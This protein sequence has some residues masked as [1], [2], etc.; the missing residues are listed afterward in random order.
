MARNLT[1]HLPSA[2]EW[3]LTTT[4]YLRAH[5]VNTPVYRRDSWEIDWD[6][7]DGK[8]VWARN[9]YSKMPSA[10]EWHWIEQKT[11]A[12]SE[13]KWKPRSTPEP[14]WVN[15]N[16]YVC[17]GRR[18]MTDDEIEI[19]D[20]R[21]LFKGRRKLFVWEHQL[22]ATMK[23]GMIPDGMLVRHLNGNK[24]DNRPENL[25]LGY[26]KENA[27]DHHSALLA[28]MVWREIATGL[29]CQLFR[30]QGASAA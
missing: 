21:G 15:H 28:M 18:A 23:Y 20:E 6:V 27:M 1:G 2:R 13:I 25:V 19:A 3:H 12:R 9:P 10:R 29:A 26:A 7:R 14:R 17:L 16:G 11:L 5:G 4:G 22:V 24:C 8:K 30:L